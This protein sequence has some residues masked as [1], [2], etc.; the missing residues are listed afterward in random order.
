[1]FMQV[2]TLKNK[3]YAYLRALRTYFNKL[4]HTL[5]NLHKT[6]NG[7]LNYTIVEN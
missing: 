2:I 5:Q 6:I 1:M 4:I 3:K 7:Q